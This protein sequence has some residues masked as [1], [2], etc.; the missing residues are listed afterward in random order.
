VNHVYRL[1][2]NRALG[3]IQV[4]S[5]LATATSGG[6]SGPRSS[7]HPHRLAQACALLLATGTAGAVFPA[8]AAT[9]VPDATHTCG[10]NGGNGGTSMSTA[11]GAGGIGSNN[12][13]G[14]G[15]ANNG[16]SG[17]F[18]AGTSDG[19]GSNGSG[20]AGSGG[21]AG[22]I[23]GGG[24]GG[25]G[26]TGGGNGG[27][28]T[29]GPGGGGGGGI[30]NNGVG[31]GGGGGWGGGGNG[32]GG[33]GGGGGVG[34]QVN[35]AFTNTISLGGGSGGN[36]SNGFEAAGSDA[37][38][39]A[40]GGGGAG[41]LIATAGITMTNLGTL[42]GGDGGNGG[43][44]AVSGTQ[45]GSG[46]GGGGGSAIVVK[47][48][49]VTL[50]NGGT[51]QGGNG[52]KGGSG[53]Y[54]G[55]GGG[56]GAGVVG[57]GFS[58][59]NTG[60]I[61]GGAGGSQ[62][63]GAN[64]VIG[65]GGVG[66][67]ATGNVTITN[68]GSISGGMAGDGVTRADAILFTGTDNTLHLQT[69]SSIVG[70][71]E[72][73]NGAGA[74][75]G[76]LDAG[77]TLDNA[78][79]LD[80]AAS[81]LT[82]DAS[83]ANLTASGVI[84]G[85][86][87]LTKT[88]AGTLILTGSNTFSGGTTVDG[89]TLSVSSDANLGASTGGVTLDGGTLQNTAA[90]TLN[91]TLSLG[92]NG[93][94]LQTDADL[95]VTQAIIGAGSLI[96]NGA[97]TLTLGGDVTTAGSQAY[98]G[99]V[100]LGADIGMTSTGGGDIGFGSTLD[101]AHAL[102]ANT[103]GVTSFGT[104]GG[105]TALTSLTTN[106]GGSTALGGNVTTTGAQTYN[107]AVLL[108]A[109]IALSS[110]GAG[111][112]SF[113]STV[114]GGHNLIVNTGGTTVFG[115]AVGG[116]TAL[117]S[118]TTNAGGSTQLGGNVTT[119]GAQQYNDSVGLAAN[120][121]LTGS[122]VTFGS[123]VDGSQ[124]LSVDATGAVN[125][126]GAVGGTSSLSSLTVAGGTFNASDLT[127]AG[128]LSVTTSAGGITQSSGVFTVLGT[129]NFNAGPNAITLTSAGNDF[130]GAVSLSGGTTAINDSN[131]LT[132]GILATA[133]LTATSSGALNL[134]SGTVGGNLAAASNNGSVTQSGSLSVSGTSTV[135]AGSGS[136]TLTNAG[137][138]FTGAV[139]LSGDNT[140]VTD[141]NSLAL[142]TLSTA[143][144]A[145][146]ST[147]ALN[148]GS[149]S[150]SG[151]LVATS[152]NGAINQSGALAVGGS[153]AID[154]GAAAI[155]L[156]NA[157]NDF[158]GAVSLG[159][160]GANNIAIADANALVLGA[161]T[162]GSGTLSLMANG[163]TQAGAIVQ[164]GAAGAVTLDAGG[165]DLALTDANNDFS[166]AVTLGSAGS[167]AVVDRNDLSIAS[168]TSG[169][170]AD[171]SLIAGGV[172]ALSPFAINT[173]NG[174]LTVASNG[175]S[176]ATVGDLS[177]GAVSL[178][179]RD[180]VT[181]GN[182]V[183]GT[184]VTLDTTN[185]AIAQVAGTLVASTLTGSSG[186]GNVTLT[187]AGNSIGTLGDFSAGNFSLIDSQALAITG[188][189]FAS[190][191]ITL[192]DS[193]GITVTG[194]VSA[195]GSTT[196]IGGTSMTI[197][198]GGTLGSLNGDVIDDGLLAFDHSD[199]VVFA[200]AISGS[201]Q[202]GQVGTGT[203]ALDGDSSAFAGS[204]SVDS[205]TLLV[206]SSAG[207]GAALGGN[208]G[209]DSGATLGGHGAI[210]GDIDVAGGA[211]LAPGN[212][213]GT[214]SIGGNASFAQG[215]VLDFEFGAPAGDFQT[216]G[217]GD[218]VAVG[219]NLTL[220]AAVLNVTDIGG[221]GPGL[222]T[223]FSYGGTL[224]YS[225]GGLVLGAMPG[226][227]TLQIQ[228]LTGDKQIN[229]LD[230]TGM[231]LNFWNG[232]GL[233]TSTSLG[234]GDGTWST[235]SMSWTDAEASVT[236]AMQPQP[237]FA[238][239]G[240]AAGTVT[241]DNG[242][243]AVS[244]TGLQFASD[245]YT[246]QGDTLTLAGTGAVTPV[247]RVGDGS[248]A[249][250]GM[251]ATIDNVIA[252]SDGLA[253]TDAGT[254]VLAGANTFSG[255]L[256]IEGGELSV[257]S[258]ANL[259]DAGNAVTLDGGVLQVTGIG[260]TSTARDLVLGDNGGGFDIADAANVFTVDQ[261][262][263]GSGGFFKA[264]AGTLVL[265]GANTFSG[266]TTI[267]A[268]T[269]QLGNGG[270][271]GMIAGDVVDNGT[272]AFDRSDAVTFANTI[273]GTGALEQ[274][275]GGTT[276]LTADNSFTGGTTIHA[277]TLQLGSGGTTGMIA[278]DVVDNGTLA[279]DRSDDISFAG[280]ISG[281]GKLV[282]QGDGTLT[283]DND[284]S[285]F[286]GATDVQSGTLVVGS[287]AGSGAALGGDVAVAGGAT[288]GGH[289]SIGGDVVNAG[290]LAPGASIGTLTIHGDYTQAASG[291]LEVDVT[292]GGRSDLLVVDGSATLA[293]GA[294]AIAIDGDWMPRTDYTILTADGG[295]S[296]QF[297]SA[298][299]NLLFLDPVL[300]YGANAVT[301]SLQRNDIVFASAAL[302]RNQRATATAA[303]GLGW[304][305]AAY[306]ALTTL[307]ADSAPQAFD[308]LSG[309][310]HASA[311]A[312]LL[313]DSRYL[314]EAIREHLQSAGAGGWAAAWGHWARSDGDGNA[315]DM[316]GDG[317]G[318]AVGTDFA[319][320]DRARLGATVGS[321]QLTVRTDARASVADVDS[322]HLAVYGS[323]DA[324]M[325]QLQAGVAGSWHDV[326]S[327]RAAAFGHY[328]DTLQAD[329]NART[330]Q[331]YLD[332]SH[333]FALGHG[334]V[335]PFLNLAQVRVRSDGFNETGGDASL[336]L[337][338]A[339]D[340][341]SHATVGARWS[342]AFG[343]HDAVQFQ[344][345]LGWMHAFGG[346]D[347]P[348]NHARFL[349]GSDTFEIAGVPIAGD[350]AVLDAGL[351]WQA[352]PRLLIDASYVGRFGS[353]ARDQGG[354]LTVNW[355]F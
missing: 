285:V 277:G 33:G 90:F 144:L 7:L 225:N 219:G 157:G 294:V 185:A 292:P 350:A 288:L 264:G 26:G 124:A 252:G 317:L 77:L 105:I 121:T 111:S 133:A 240:G 299:S 231:T 64:G 291:T 215:S 352:D 310:V 267:G 237:G 72:L 27:S 217:T 125:F 190:G 248:S 337:D 347:A 170:D 132:L 127:V 289:G 213:V 97:G 312:A 31:G 261:A 320:G 28:G 5:E 96:Q 205:G 278:G 23:S 313:D 81:A 319:I 140:Q 245:G 181:L 163:I 10:I 89:G 58:L 36:G 305:N 1:V 162:V 172:L 167:V 115:G 343:G 308:A 306:A 345:S 260:F 152:N 137:N 69:G 191:D 253:K 269:L 134:G 66:V 153:A 296:G 349:T 116:I 182:N 307:D 16:G 202:L 329:Y 216:A 2:F 161:S 259:G 39:G 62:G 179:G 32:G 271:T 19:S 300:S 18:R 57:A 92:A 304:G 281:S 339:S 254:L 143:N 141:Q 243:G 206:G 98:N 106:A 330:T 128:P 301:L 83:S 158:S 336:Q 316:R 110:S 318:F 85:A 40:G 196:L 244:A 122:S 275:G 168:L 327:Q 298:T 3:V 29:Y 42:S 52:G 169:T 227:E 145:A 334:R 113:N 274:Q 325:L 230:T 45:S 102:T 263:D 20:M 76:A 54:A 84:S 268:G 59:T 242:D 187:N 61:A 120:V 197:G 100:A 171:V 13:A 293:G 118:L 74:T 88:G 53:D 166:G 194:S 353:D 335:A 50:V 15:S 93:G 220:D 272:L 211:H 295:V 8:M 262:L 178:T 148:L 188:A 126:F 354:R 311:R 297:G 37:D 210:G 280:T 104:V 154:A 303:D 195:G 228:N 201:G 282:Q 65:Q 136:I 6:R 80:D 114:D 119:T 341:R 309:E 198:N 247:I 218:S 60:S 176:F 340:E 355:A 99:P 138:D 174:A 11:G 75:I 351:R 189:L 200:G 73:G 279:F 324:G 38:G 233:A 94:T 151:N 342:T 333:A 236:A 149:G 234:G 287:F 328:A 159:N 14:D 223:L 204:T 284:N 17:G 348:L 270:T 265:A 186:T 255:G 332:A 193:A 35:G 156:N 34:Q 183:M 177:G 221:M 101:G 266:G 123:T 331:A 212:S 25:S 160:S 70:T 30:A 103:T 315:A 4:V 49:N 51:V 344:G 251:T 24:V 130:A 150:V 208:V 276:I 229:L 338:A 273:S 238:I 192:G 139:S 129:S 199:D 232:N 239:F 48:T 224:T 302:T 47:A 82:F 22:R 135:N 256:T 107:D 44:G 283:L 314:R 68:S 241:V 250:A 9:C 180:G 290:T 78:I 322:R 155:T 321:S 21:G 257:A 95:T 346:D 203:L 55:G 146:V 86:G 67:V 63:S 12:G 56:G 131:A 184:T 235:T 209:V 46:S 43:N 165:G 207:N 117:A 173:G 226:S 323:V 112:I 91:H 175:G 214:L 87:S 41:A 258:D 286:D 142:G 147:G 222:Y 109:D 108:G 249:G 79:R 164:A 246:L 326:G 71:I